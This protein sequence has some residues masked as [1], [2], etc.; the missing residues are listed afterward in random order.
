MYQVLPP[1]T[2]TTA[3]ELPLGRVASKECS[4]IY[5]VHA[6][7]VW[8]S[9]RIALR[10]CSSAKARRPTSNTLRTI[11]ECNWMCQ[12]SLCPKQTRKWLLIFGPIPK[13]TWPDDVI[14]EK[15]SLNPKSEVPAC[16]RHAL[17]FWAVFS[18]FRGFCWSPV[19]VWDVLF[20]AYAYTKVGKPRKPCNTWFLENCWIKHVDP[21][22]LS[23]GNA[24]Q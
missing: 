21:I 6:G 19:A 7:N 1:P 15:P 17:D 22:G 10:Q 9:H 24:L 3:C 12:N 18:I 11:L 13:P 2:T 8:K 23:L 5:F 20:V 14:R 4:P 16:P